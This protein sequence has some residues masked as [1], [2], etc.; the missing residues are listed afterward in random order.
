M[1]PRISGQARLRNLARQFEK[2]NSEKL[3]ELEL[4]IRVHG[5]LAAEAEDLEL[6]NNALPYV[7][8]KPPTQP[9]YTFTLH[10]LADR[11][12]MVNGVL[13]ERTQADA[14]T[15]A[16]RTAQYFLLGLSAATMGI[17]VWRP[18]SVG[19][20]QP[21]ARDLSADVQITVDIAPAGGPIPRTELVHAGHLTTALDIMQSVMG[22]HVR[23]LE[24]YQRGEILLELPVWPLLSFAEDAY[25]SFFKCFEYLV[26]DRIL[27]KKGQLS[28]KDFERALGAVGIASDEPMKFGKS[29]IET[30]GRRAAHMLKGYSDFSV[31]QQDVYE[32]KKLVDLIAGEVARRE[33]GSHR[34]QG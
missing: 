8:I 28:P 18:L 7:K 26:M 13:T 33:S 32:L 25:L 17:V 24:V 4:S 14:V 23:F 6:F 3:V 1:T 20:Q 19:G 22:W 29:L 34:R 16:L 15:N 5:Y 11:F 31:T 27:S 9:R 12:L 2:M 30:R 21:I 10:T